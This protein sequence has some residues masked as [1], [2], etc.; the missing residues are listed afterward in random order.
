MKL[1]ENK[2]MKGILIKDETVTGDIL[3]QILIEVETE[4]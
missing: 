1:K 2:V 4:D 3:N